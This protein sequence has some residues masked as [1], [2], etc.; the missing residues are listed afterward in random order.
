MYIWVQSSLCGLL[1]WADPP[2]GCFHVVFLDI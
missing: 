1:W 2:L